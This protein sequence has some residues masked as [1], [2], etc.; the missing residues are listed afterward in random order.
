MFRAPIFNAV[1]RARA[2]LLLALALLL[3]GCAT[4]SGPA[5]P[6]A[7]APPAPNRR[8]SARSNAAPAFTLRVEAEDKDLRALIERHGVLPR[9]RSVSDL[10]DTELARLMALGAQDARKL[11]AT[12]G[13]F[14]PDVRVRR[15]G[16][17]ESAGAGPPV[18]VIAID[19]GPATTVT[20]VDV[21]FA[22]DI[23]TSDDAAAQAQRE[24]I[25]GG[26]RLGPGQR[27]TQDGWAGAKTGALRQLVEQRYPRGRIARSQADVDAPT[28]EARLGLTLD[29]GPP[30]YLGPAR[31]EGARRYP[32][33]L[34]ERL[35]WLKPGD[36]YDQ[37]KLVDA[38]QRLAGSG[39]YD[40]AYI[41]IDPDG[42]PAATPVTYSVTEARRQK[43]QL[44]VGYSTD[45]GPRL[46]LEHRHNTAFGTTWRADT[47]LQLDR[48]TPLLQTEFSSLPDA[49]GWRWAGLARYMRQDD[50]TLNTLSKT[51][52]AGRIQNTEHYDRHFYVQYDHA[53]V[54]GSGAAP[55]PDALLG[56]GAA[57]SANMAWTARHFDHMQSPTR[58]YGLGFE[59]G[60]GVTTVGPRQPFTRAVGRWLGFVPLGTGASRLALRAE[61][62]AV[63]A[64]SS[65]RLPGTYLFRT[66]GDT[67]VRGYGY[68]SI[69]IDVGSNLVG[70]GRYMAV[71][72][73]EWQRPILQERF[74][75]LLEHTL[76][77][78]VGSVANH[79]GNLRARWGV[80]TGVRLLTPVGPM[81]IDV[82]HGFTPHQWR[83]H[84][85]VGFVF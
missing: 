56:D 50:G 71:G 4:L 73:A 1:S 35:S 84:M 82:A 36:V 12:E 2:P 7:D 80:G 85:N 16:A 57:I 21:G 20:A 22:G 47:R 29:S 79:V 77:I 78:D 64:G 54:T 49:G 60:A 9:Y 18:I 76:F 55:V 32:G 45:A 41:A 53:T 33:E 61:A 13:Y 81:Q 72:S 38:Q 83:L 46:T 17:G 31:V 5:E 19:P 66:G 40:S 3:G 44:G 14:S 11:L 24:A 48:K 43:V 25:R 68:R 59:L 28:H 34:A 62:G 26:W 10:D 30:F 75:G 27:F 67:T 6:Q 23:A 63:L 37:K 51:L 70:P 39:Y 58:G 8:A 65:A 74:P 15:E 52:R 69:G 42:D